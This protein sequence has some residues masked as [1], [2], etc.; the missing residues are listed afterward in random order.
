MRNTRGILAVTL[1]GGGIAA[2]GG[3]IFTGTVILLEY[4]MPFSREIPGLLASVLGDV[5]VVFFVGGA[6]TTGGFAM[7]LSVTGR[8]LTL[9]E[10]SV[11]RAT[12]TGGV[13]GMLLPIAVIATTAGVSYALDPIIEGM[14]VWIGFGAAGAGVSGG[15]AAVAKRSVRQELRT[16]DEVI[17]PIER[18]PPRE[19]S[20]GRP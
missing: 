4:G 8:T 9:T 16:P 13:I 14:P 7:L 15:L 19:S 18:T 6:I 1:I 10:L 17:A 3:V 5:A 2:T 12:L 20:R 11:S